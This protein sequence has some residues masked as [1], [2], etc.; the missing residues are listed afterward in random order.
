M[1]EVLAQRLKMHLESKSD[2]LSP[3]LPRAIEVG[4][5]YVPYAYADPVVSVVKVSFYPAMSSLPPRS[6]RLSVGLSLGG[7]AGVLRS[8][9]HLLGFQFLL[10]Y[11]CCELQLDHAS[12]S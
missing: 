5:G 8:A 3:K 10:L 12:A 7:L 9:C 11:C 1:G 6:R 2:P 4:Q